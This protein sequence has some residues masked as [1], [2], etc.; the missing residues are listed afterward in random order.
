MKVMLVSRSRLASTELQ[1]GGEVYR[2][3]ESTPKASAP[4]SLHPE[5]SGTWDL[6]RVLLETLNPKP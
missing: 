6:R 1:L 5:P 4:N 2:T 3:L